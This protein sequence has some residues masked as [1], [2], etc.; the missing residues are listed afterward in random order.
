MKGFLWKSHFEKMCSLVRT[1]NNFSGE[2]SRNFGDL[3][4]FFGFFAGTFQFSSVFCIREAA[5]TRKIFLISLGRLETTYENHLVLDRDFFVGWQKNYDLW[6]ACGMMLKKNIW[7]FLEF[8][9]FFKVKFLCVVE[10]N[11]LLWEKNERFF[12]EDL[13]WKCGSFA[14]F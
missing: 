6:W 9:E 11:G 12:W 5:R 3:D 10:W 8:V 7:L 14:G 13:K 4:S 2:I 1:W